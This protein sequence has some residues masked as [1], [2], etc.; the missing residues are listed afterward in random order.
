MHED[1]SIGSTFNVG[2]GGSLLGF[3]WGAIM[4]PAPTTP[5]ACYFKNVSNR[6]SSYLIPTQSWNVCEV[7]VLRSCTNIFPLR[8]K[9]HEPKLL[10]GWT[11]S[12]PL[13]PS[14]RCNAWL[15]VVV[16]KW[17]RDWGSLTSRNCKN[18]KVEK[19]NLCTNSVQESDVIHMM[20]FCFVFVTL[21]LFAF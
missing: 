10:D 7:A 3:L 18:D 8:I 17:Y 21:L 4:D 6:H 13:P 19:F 12:G 16:L 2:G 15:D 11:K 5:S 9:K 14:R 1:R 20:D